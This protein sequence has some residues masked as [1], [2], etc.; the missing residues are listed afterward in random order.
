MKICSNYIHI[1][2]VLDKKRKSSIIVIFV[3]IFKVLYLFHLLCYFLT[4]IFILIIIWCIKNKNNKLPHKFNIK[5]IKKNAVTV[6][7]NKQH[8]G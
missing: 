3:N 8:L 4:V 2:V 6:K 5:E 7:R 1:I